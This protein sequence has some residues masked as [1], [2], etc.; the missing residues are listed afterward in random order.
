MAAIKIV[1]I[2]EAMKVV[3]GKA[4]VAGITRVLI[5]MAI[6]TCKSLAK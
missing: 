5:L 2:K 6:D 4:A 3:I 1:V